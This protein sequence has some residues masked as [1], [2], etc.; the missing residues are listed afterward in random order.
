MKR[1][2]LIPR[3]IARRYAFGGN[4]VA[5]FSFYGGVFII[6]A[7][8]LMLQIIETRIISV[9]SWYHLAFFVIS[10]AMFGLAAGAVWVFLWCRDLPPRELYYRLTIHSLGF[11][12]STVLSLLMQMTMVTPSSSTSLTTL[13]AWTELA[14]CLAVPFFFSGVVVSLA[15]T[16]SPYPIGWVYGADLIGAAIGQAIRSSW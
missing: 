15:L 2:L 6:A 4:A 7:A 12:V 8:T 1:W 14:I 5:R 11:A 16:R 9:T 13:F 10:T 3:E